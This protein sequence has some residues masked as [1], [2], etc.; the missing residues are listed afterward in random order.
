M[1]SGGE[2]MARNVL[3]IGGE[4]GALELEIERPPKVTA[5]YSGKLEIFL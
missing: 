2:P 3:E 4:L 1:G 5:T